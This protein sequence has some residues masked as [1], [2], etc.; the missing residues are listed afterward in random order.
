MV[1]M[2][3]KQW[4]CTDLFDLFDLLFPRATVLYWW[5]LCNP[6]C[7][8]NLCC[9]LGL[10]VHGLKNLVFYCW[11]VSFILLCLPLP[12]LK[13]YLS[14]YRVMRYKPWILKGVLYWS[15]LYSEPKYSCIQDQITSP[16]CPQHGHPTIRCNSSLLTRSNL[17]INTFF[18]PQKWEKPWAFLRIGRKEIILKM[19]VLV[20]CSSVSGA[21]GVLS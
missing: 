11:L 6:E 8:E 20:V 17:M 19:C 18:I 2:W 10:S 13:P 16:Q 7:H 15:R 12:Q 1:L 21:K 3:F 4:S 14:H 5:W 9:S